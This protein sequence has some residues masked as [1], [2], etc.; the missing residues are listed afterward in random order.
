MERVIWLPGDGGQERLSP[1]RRPGLLAKAAA[2]LAGAAALV[3]VQVAAAP[4][5]PPAVFV[6]PGKG[7]KCPVCGMFVHKYPDWAAGI[8][9]KDG[10]REV[11]DGAKDLFR[12]YSDMRSFGGKKQREDVAAV[13]VTDYYTLEPIDAATALFVVGSDVYG[14]MGKE[15]IPFARRPEAEEFLRDHGGRKIIGFDEAAPEL[16]ALLE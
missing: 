5:P 13:F 2:A 8:V 4:A 3:S 7:E 11:F 1:G 10:S 12:Y 14:P 9:F 15:L 6:K 16:P